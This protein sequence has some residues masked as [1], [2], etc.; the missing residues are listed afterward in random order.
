MCAVSSAA[1]G[2]VSRCRI[3]TAAVAQR[4]LFRILL[5]GHMVTDS[6]NK[7]VV[8]F[9]LSRNSESSGPYDLLTGTYYGSTELPKGALTETI[10]VPIEKW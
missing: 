3:P 1:S 2:P 4:G 7:D 8:P 5:G 10:T 9:S 6:I